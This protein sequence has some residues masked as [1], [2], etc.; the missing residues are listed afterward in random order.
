MV[1]LQAR[2]AAGRPRASVDLVAPGFERERDAIAV[3][4][5]G[6]QNAH[7]VGRRDAQLDDAVVDRLEN[8]EAHP[9]AEALADGQLTHC[10]ACLVEQRCGAQ[11][12]TAGA[13]AGRVGA[14]ITASPPCCCDP[15]WRM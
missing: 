4:V 2:W 10:L 14:P 12:D 1:E 3:D 8:V 7:A 15:D 6:C 13:D 11:S 5:V 9:D